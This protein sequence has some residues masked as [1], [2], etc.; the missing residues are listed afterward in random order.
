MRREDL[1]THEKQLHSLR[2][3]KEGYRQLGIRVEHERRSVPVHN[4]IATQNGI[5]E[6]KYEMVRELIEKGELDVPVLVEEHYVDGGYRRYLIDGHTR[7]RAFI[8]LGERSIE[9]FVVWSPAGDWPSNFV[10]VAAQY[11]NALVKDLPMI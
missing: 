10:Q 7:V 4:L 11:G 6:A 1:V 5:E 2:D 3:V 8:D 9:A